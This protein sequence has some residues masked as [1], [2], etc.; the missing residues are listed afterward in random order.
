M[1][2]TVKNGKFTGV[3]YPEI[4]KVIKKW[5]EENNLQIIEVET[6]PIN[7][8]TEY[9]PDYGSPSYSDFIPKHIS[10][11]QGRLALLEKGYLDKVE[12]EIEKISDL[13][14]RRTVLIEYDS[15]TW[16]RK[17]TFLQNIWTNIGGTQEELDDLF[18]LAEKK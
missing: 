4:S 18:L 2:A 17:N 6:I 16:E 9:D 11:R 15:E 8:G 1:F 14:Q 12:K 7:K 3:T 13:T 5:H 10:R